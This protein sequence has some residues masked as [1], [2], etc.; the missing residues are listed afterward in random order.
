MSDIRIIYHRESL[1]QSIASDFI[2]TGMLFAFVSMGVWLDSTAMQWLGAIVGFLWLIS[3]GSRKLKNATFL[4]TDAVRAHLDK[5]DA[6][7]IPSHA[8]PAQ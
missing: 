6:E 5:I 3:F 7:S 8:E 2:S 1:L 4:S